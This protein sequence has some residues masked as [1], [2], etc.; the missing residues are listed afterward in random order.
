MTTID[1]LEHRVRL[2]ELAH[3]RFDSIDAT[4]KQHSEIL[5]KHSAILDGHS[6]ILA[7][8]ST[9]LTMLQ[10]DVGGIRNELTGLRVNIDAKFHAAASQME[11]IIALLKRD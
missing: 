6:A 2:L 5:Q 7:Q 8:H 11:T 3:N 9:Q 4:L 1:E 10:Q